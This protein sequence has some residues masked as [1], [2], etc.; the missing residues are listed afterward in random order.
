MTVTAIV[1]YLMTA[2]GIGY[3]GGAIIRIGKK[4]IESAE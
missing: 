4:A 1:G 2:F 3:A